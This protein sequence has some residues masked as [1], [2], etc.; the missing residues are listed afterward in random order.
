MSV[1]LTASFLCAA[2]ADKKAE[3]GAG[4][5]TEFQF[6]STRPWPAVP[7]GLMGNVVQSQVLIL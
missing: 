6:V 7:Q 1:F 2:G 4:A 5:S 3:A